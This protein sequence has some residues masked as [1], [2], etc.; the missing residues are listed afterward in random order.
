MI[1]GWLVLNGFIKVM[2]E[3]RRI[4]RGIGSYLD[5]VLVQLVM[6]KLQYRK[7]CIK[8]FREEILGGGGEQSI[9]EL[10]GKFFYFN[11]CVNRVL[12]GL[13]FILRN[14]G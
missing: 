7:L 13:K 4:V 8:E 10:W 12:K 6:Q 5:I 9:S 3:V 11:I 1:Q 2:C 14:N